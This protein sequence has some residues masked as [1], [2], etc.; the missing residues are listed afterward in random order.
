VTGITRKGS[1]TALP[2]GVQRA[3][4]DYDDPKS[5]VAAFQGQDFVVITLYI[6]APPDRHSML[7]KAAAEAGVQ[8]VMP[9]IYGTDIRNTK[10]KDNA[11]YRLALD[12][13]AE[14]ERLG[15]KHFSMASA[16]WYEWS[17]A[18][19]EG[20]FGFEINDRTATMFDDGRIVVPTTTWEACGA[21]LAALL[22]LPVSGASPCLMDWANEPLYL[23]SFQLSQRDMLDSI[24]RILGTTDADWTITYE[25]TAERSRKGLELFA[26][27]GLQSGGMGKHLYALYFQKSKAG[28]NKQP[29]DD[30]ETLGVPKENLDDAT[31]RAVDMVQSGWTVWSPEVR[32]KLGR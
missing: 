22:S 18:A 20:W 28:E 30:L 10:Q 17:V 1:D 7:V 24:H 11:M 2:E 27:S 29:K 19:G 9:N 32:A 23:L 16:V 31:R 26:K 13:V 3:E 6:F 8:Y 5:L 25:T 12:M 14:M 4:I 15:L 21:A